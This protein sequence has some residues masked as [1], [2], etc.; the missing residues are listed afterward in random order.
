MPELWIRDDTELSITQRK[1]HTQIA[2]IRM[3]CRLEV[4]NLKRKKQKMKSKGQKL[5]K[6]T[7]GTVYRVPISYRLRRVMAQKKSARKLE[8]KHATW[9]FSQAS[10]HHF[11]HSTWSDLRFYLV[12]SMI[13]EDRNP[14]LNLLSMEKF[15]WVSV[16]ILIRQIVV[17]AFTEPAATAGFNVLSTSG[18]GIGNSQTA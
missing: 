18:K 15:L 12:R 17:A 7:H 8:A 5:Y 9:F 13:K 16:D 10:F 3:L 6:N 2:V 11:L 14:A 4:G 1:G